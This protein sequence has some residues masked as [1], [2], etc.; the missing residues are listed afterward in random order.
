ME[1]LGVVWEEMGT[2]AVEVEELE[3]LMVEMVLME[4]HML[5]DMETRL[6]SQLST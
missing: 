6:T 3:V 5:V 2:V 4:R 1:A